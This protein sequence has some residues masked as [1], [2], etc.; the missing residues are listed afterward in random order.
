VERGIADSPDVLPEFALLVL[1]RTIPR[2]QFLFP[3]AIWIPGWHHCWY[4]TLKDVMSSLEWFPAWLA[5][6]KS[7]CQFLK[8]EH[9]RKVWLRHAESAGHPDAKRL[10]HWSEA[11]AEWRWDTLHS[12]VKEVSFLKSL[13]EATWSQNL[14]PATKP[15]THLTDVD[16]TLRDPIWWRRLGV[17]YDVSREV[18]GIRLWADGCPCHE[19]QLKAGEQ[20]N[21]SWQGRRLPEAAAI[22]AH[23]CHLWDVMA[24]DVTV[25][26][27]GTQFEHVVARTHVCSN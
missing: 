8:Q 9:Y 12:A 21:C 13:S 27:I 5:G 20:V 10:S 6:L 3:R 2:Q 14:F 1:R 16:K 25:A 22:V 18:E 17:V 7:I 11:F 4:N 15:G 19:E 26:D 24:D 23:I